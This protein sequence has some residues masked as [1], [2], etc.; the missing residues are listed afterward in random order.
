MLAAEGWQAEVLAKGAFLGGLGDGAA[1]LVA[2]GADGLLVDDRGG[3]HPT[4]GFRRFT[5]DAGQAVQEVAR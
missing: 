1:L 3:L 4:A 2:V 5:V